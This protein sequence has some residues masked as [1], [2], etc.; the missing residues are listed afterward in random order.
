MKEKIVTKNFIFAFMSQFCSAMVMYMLLGT[1]TEYAEGMGT[2]VTLA[3]MVS[4][5]Y[6]FGGL[7]AR[8]Y[9]C[10]GLDRWG[11]KRL[12]MM[13]MILHFVVCC[14]YFLV[15]NIAV[16]ILVRFIHGLG[17][18][19]AANATMTI[20]MSFFPKSRYGEATG[21]FM[22]STT[23][24]VAVGPFVGG[25][26]YDVFGG[27]GCFTMACILSFLM[28]VFMAFVDIRGLDPGSRKKR[29][30]ALCMKKEESA[31]G[32]EIRGA[33]GDAKPQA[34]GLNRFIEVKAIPVSL[35]I[36]MCAFG[37]VA[38]MS[39][40]RLFAVEYDLTDEF[41]YFFL[42][43]GGFLLLTR[44]FGGKLQDKYG[45]NVIC[46]PG[47]LG[48]AIG[49]A[50]VAWHPCMVTIIICALGCSLGFGMLSSACN[51]IV[52]R[53]AGPERRP[54]AITTFWLCCDGGVGIGPSILGAIAAAS[55]FQTM[56]FAAAIITFIGLPIYYFSYGRKYRK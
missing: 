32:G 40:Y 14:C 25:K 36:L 2:T 22:L 15:D 35:C 37:Y 47:V 3:G 51:V 38:I 10:I 50:C 6:V 56:Y 13:A 48:Q 5:I 7:C 34:K 52:C 30:R 18:G 41:A 44:T 12:A 1:I 55:G 16:L 28:V 27:T 24:A 8:L 29:E 9:S 39:F 42:F 45:D 20:C 33:A 54:Y 53:Q 23:L 49:I 46:I 26:V 4:G 43:Y 19:A 31:G 11:W 21:Y 17:F